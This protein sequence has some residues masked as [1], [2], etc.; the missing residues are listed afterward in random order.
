M[1]ARVCTCVSLVFYVNDLYIFNTLPTTR[2]SNNS[3]LLATW[4]SERYVFKNRFSFDIM[5]IHIFEQNLRCVWCHIKSYCIFLRLLIKIGRIIQLFRGCAI[6]FRG[7]LF[8]IDEDR[9]GFYNILHP[10]D[11]TLMAVSVVIRVNMVCMSMN[12]CLTSR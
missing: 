6:I 1:C 4:Y 5:K 8:Y 11:L 7:K 9:R 12:A 10:N 3:N 2:S